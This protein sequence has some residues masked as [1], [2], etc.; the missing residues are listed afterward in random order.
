MDGEPVPVLEGVLM[1]PGAGA[2]FAFAS[3]GS[4]VYVTGVAGSTLTARLVW[5]DRDG[6]EGDE[7]IDAPLEGP[8]YP[9]VSPDGRR[10]ALTLGPA[11]QGDLW[12]YDL[13]LSGFAKDV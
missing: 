6:R 12:V 1:T 5:V 2:Q 3:D 4:L 9:R 11:N 7:I 10:L 8:R 13:G